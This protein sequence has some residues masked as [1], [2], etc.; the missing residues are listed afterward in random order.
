MSKNAKLFIIL[1]LI[2]CV[3][4]AAWILLSRADRDPQPTEIDKEDLE[5]L[6]E[7]EEFD[8]EEG[9]DEALIEE[10]DDDVPEMTLE[11]ALPILEQDG[12]VRTAEG[13]KAKDDSEGIKSERM[14]TAKGNNVFV[15]LS[16]DYGSDSENKSMTA[17]FKDDTDDAV[18]IMVSSFL[19]RL[20]GEANAAE[21]SMEYVIFI[22]G[23]EA[24]TGRMS[25]EEAREYSMMGDEF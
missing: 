16:Y 11:Q 20:A 24:V 25:L 6:D 3:G 9:D 18:S 12:Y 22:G 1:A 10:E 21:G 4:L 15:T 14:V 23:K 7:L 19:T 13:Y 8:G 5:Y 17:F 2:A